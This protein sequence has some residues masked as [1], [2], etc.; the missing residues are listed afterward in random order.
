MYAI[1][2][3]FTQSFD[4]IWFTYKIPKNLKD[5][6]KIGMIVHIPF[7]KK[8]ILWIILE[9]QNES[10]F[11]HL[12]IK[13]IWDIYDSHIFL[14][15]YQI[16]V[17]KWLSV[18]YFA[19]IHSST[20]LFFPKNLLW[21]IVKNKFHFQTEISEYHYIFDYHKTLHLNQKKIFEEI[22]HSQENK[23]LLYGVTGSGKTEIYIHL[24]KYY[25]DQWKQSLLLVPEI[26]LTN[27]IFERMKKVFGL[28][29]IILNSTVS[30]GKK[31]LYWEM[32]Y[33][34]KAKIIIGTRSAI[35][36]PYN[37]LWIIIIDEE[38]DNSYLSDITP[39]YDT[40]ELATQIS[41]L[42]HIKL[43]LWSWT[44]KMNHLYRYL[45]WE[46]KVLNLFEEYK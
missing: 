33:Q 15:P 2:S 35:F 17:L 4:D 22:I 41:K 39:R 46:W 11:D 30:E 31:T 1:I 44:P 23:F 7:W 21:K 24:I 40:I 42:T 38:H 6:I 29:V 9:L 14:N 19:L 12:K 36:Y 5:I 28:E 43:V 27:Q 10:S 8:N 25:L 13:E 34:N 16:Y 20:S 26:I 37:N 3:P 45:Q 32:I 18:H